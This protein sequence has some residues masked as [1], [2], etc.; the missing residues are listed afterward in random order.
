MS[1]TDL[2][3]A[4]ER[5]PSRSL[6]TGDRAFEE[7]RSA[8]GAPLATLRARGVV[9]LGDHRQSL[10]V[11]RSLG[12]AGYRIIAGGPS[13]RTI[14]EHSRCVAEVWNHA[15]HAAPRDWAGALQAFCA[16]REDVGVVFPVGDDEIDLAA[17]LVGRLPVLI[18]MVAPSILAV[19]RSKRALLALAEDC[20][21]P[22][23]PWESVE[24]LDAL[25]PALRQV[26][27]PAVLKPEANAHPALGFK[28][29]ILRSAADAHR[30]L[31]HTAFPKGGFVLQRPAG[32]ARHNVYFVAR[33][34]R[35]LGH[36][37]VRILRTDRPD[38]TGLAVEGESV[39]PSQALLEWTEALAARLSY[40]GA[41]CAQ[42]V[43]EEA[44]GSACFLEINARL[45]ANCATA[46]ACGLDLPRLYIEALLGVAP[47]QPPATVGRRYAWLHGDL[48]GLASCL[49]SSRVTWRQGIGWLARAVV[50]QLRADHHVTWSWR[51]PL[52]TVMLFGGLFHAFFHAL[53]RGRLFARTHRAVVGFSARGTSAPSLVGAIAP[54]EP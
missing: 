9:V 42:F 45:G 19:C 20:A 23:Q 33:E 14:L 37:Q 36:V 30:L 24:S 38:G 1:G 27:L 49:G 29:A 54:R 21:V 7:M 6:W 18:V 22:T 53:I 5:S 13:G 2:A 3:P 41:G 34:G 35:V 26:G 31:A 48:A 25:V 12:R 51:D 52:P 4:V 17:P 15:R 40:T 28:A 32:G 46:C 39:P 11:A 50:A 10:T 47:Q 16:E 8:R 44:T 43:V